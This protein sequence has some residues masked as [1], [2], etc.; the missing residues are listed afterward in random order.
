MPPQP[1]NLHPRGE[2]FKIC[3]VEGCKKTAYL[4]GW[5]YSTWQQRFQARTLAVRWQQSSLR[6]H[7]AVAVQAGSTRAPSH[8]V[9]PRTMT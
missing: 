2:E 9:Q 5:D 1:P 7:M 6:S 8:S 4:H 3:Q